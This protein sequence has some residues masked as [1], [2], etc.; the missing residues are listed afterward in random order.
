LSET[1]RAAELSQLDD[2]AGPV[3]TSDIPDMLPGAAVQTLRDAIESARRRARIK[4]R[5]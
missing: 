3:D 1:A 2:P 5:V 4:S